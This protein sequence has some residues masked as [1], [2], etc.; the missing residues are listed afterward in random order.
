MESL[1]ELVA[2]I[3]YEADWEI[4]PTPVNGFR[5]H[6]MIDEDETV[7]AIIRMV[8]KYSKA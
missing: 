7:Q 2:S 6:F 4:S 1:K 5:D 8:R 3:I